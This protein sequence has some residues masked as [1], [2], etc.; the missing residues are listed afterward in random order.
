MLH[1]KPAPPSGELKPKSAVVAVVL[2]DGPESIAVSGAVASMLKLRGTLVAALP[3][4]SVC[5]AWAV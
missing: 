5:S 3:A 4:A 1:S 2:P